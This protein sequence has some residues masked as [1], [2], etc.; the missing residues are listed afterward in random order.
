ML[1]PDLSIARLGAV[2]NGPPAQMVFGPDGRLY[3]TLANFGNASAPSVESFAYSPSGGL[4]DERVE[5]STGGALGIGFGPVSLGP[6]P[7]SVIVTGMYLTDTQSNGNSNLRVLTRDTHGVWGGTA[8]NGVNTVIVQN[9]PAGYHQADQIAVRHNTDGTY[10]LFVGIGVRTKDGVND[11]PNPGNARDPAWGGTISEIRDLRQVNGRVVD[12]AGFGFT[13]NASSNTQPDYSNAGPYTST[14]ANKLVVYSSGARN[15][16]G[17]ALDGSNNLWFTNNFNRSQSDG[18]FDGTIDPSTHIMRG[19]TTG[20]PQIPGDHSDPDLRNNVYDQF[21]QA[22]FQADYGYD[23]SNWRNDANNDNPFTTSQAAVNAGF[24]DFAHHGVRSTTFDNLSMPAGGFTEYDESDINHIRGLGP[25]SSSDGFAF[26]SIDGLPPAYAGNAFIVRWSAS[27]SDSTGHSITYAD[28]VAVDPTTGNVRLIA[29]QFIHPLAVLQDSQGSMLVADYGDGSI[30]RITAAVPAPTNLTA[31]AGNGQ[32]NLSWMPAAGAVS[33]NVYRSTTS[34]GEGTTPIATGVT[35]TT[36]TDSTVTNGTTYYYQVTAVASAGQSG[37]S[38]EAFATPGTIISVNDVRGNDGASGATFNFTVSL[39]GP[40]TQTVTVSYATNPGTASPGS[41]YV[42]TSGTL[43]FLPGTTS[44]PVSV[45]VIGDTSYETNETFTLVLSSAQNGF[46][47][48]GT[49]TGTILNDDPP[50]AIS[51][52]GTSGT[53]P[54]SGSTTFTFPVTLNTASEVAAVVHFATADGTGHAG[55]DYVATSGFVTFNP[56]VTMRTITV[57][58]LHN[59]QFSGSATFFVNLSSPK[60][61]TIAVAQATG[62][63]TSGTSPVVRL[64]VAS[65]QSVKSLTDSRLWVANLNDRANLVAQAF[66][67]MQMDAQTGMFEPPAST[68]YRRVAQEKTELRDLVFQFGGL[69]LVDLRDP[70][71]HLDLPSRGWV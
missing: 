68:T 18:T 44:Q 65:P 12:S 25:S 69:E 42:S 8:A 29:N 70:S 61:A 33:Y 62:T 60:S 34:H 38:N 21:F 19:Y 30:Y 57:T 63:I 7:K 43:T 32:I 2:S 67:P 50:P 41:D 45:S 47:G 31:T 54:A 14:A 53:E 17:L 39:S 35:G 55:V 28:L 9:I 11:Y 27:I 26:D 4:S 23:S 3:V 49:G 59:P 37:K 36:Y 56:G 1:Q 58:V 40:S 6:Y 66:L 24:Y 46:I 64:D 22:S 71:R 5:V 13:G 10:T 48:R 51:I 15:P 16:F 20:D 52:A